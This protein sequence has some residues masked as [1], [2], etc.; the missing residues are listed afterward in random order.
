M[1][2]P[3]VVGHVKRNPAMFSEI[4]HERVVHS[5]YFDT[6]EFLLFHENREGLAMRSKFRLRWY[7]D[8]HD[9]LHLEEKTR[10]GLLIGKTSF[11]I[12]P[13]RFDCARTMMNTLASA[14]SDSDAPS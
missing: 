11:E 1:D 6:A 14:G 8:Q 12:P 4:Y 9:D 7:G 3:F 2:A 10:T 5:L 13:I